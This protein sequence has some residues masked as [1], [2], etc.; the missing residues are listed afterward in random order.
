MAKESANVEDISF[1]VIGG[2]IAGVTCAE[3][4]SMLC[5]EQKITLITATDVIKSVDNLR[6]YGQSLEEFEVKEKP[7]SCLSDKLPNITVIRDT[8]KAFNP[9]GELKL[10]S[11]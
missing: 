3:Y 8:V 9:K 11:D 5:P 7:L 10:C 4:L 1:L 2:G 6:R